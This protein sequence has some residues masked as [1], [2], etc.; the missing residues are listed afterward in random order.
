MSFSKRYGE[1]FKPYKSSITIDPS[2]SYSFSEKKLRLAAS[3]EYLFN[4]F[5]YAKLKIEGGQKADSPRPMLGSLNGSRS[6]V[7][8][9]L[10]IDDWNN[11]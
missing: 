8:Q 10:V 6:Y 4:R 5:N 2:V 3:G 9:N 1:R 11:D 7:G